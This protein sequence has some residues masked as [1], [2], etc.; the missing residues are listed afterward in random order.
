MAILKQCKKFA[1]F[2]NSKRTYGFYFKEIVTEEV[3][4]GCVILDVGCNLRPLLNKHESYTLHGIDAD[5]SIDMKMAYEIFDEFYIESFENF[6]ANTKYDLIILRKVLEHFENNDL[7]FEQLKNILKEDGKIVAFT[8]SNLHPFSII[9]QIIPHKLKIVLLKKL[10]PWVKQGRIGWKAYY[11]KCNIHA[12][13]KLANKY[14]LKVT[15]SY[16]D[17]NSSSYFAF[18]PPIFILIVLYEEVIKK[19]NLKLLCATFVVQ[20]EHQ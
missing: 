1:D 7:V 12:M 8:P 17:Y 18:F 15:Q 20:V 4:P 9:N 3:K 14:G 10:M 5:T 6:S 11:D 16:F 13:S 19:L 2:V